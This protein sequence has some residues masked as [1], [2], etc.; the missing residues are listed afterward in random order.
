MEEILKEKYLRSKERK[1]KALIKTDERYKKA[2]FKMY[3]YYEID[4]KMNRSNVFT[5]LKKIYIDN[6]TKA[7]WYLAYICNISR[8]TLFGHRNEM[9]KCFEVCLKMVDDEKIKEIAITK[10]FD[11]K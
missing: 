10:D 4:D 2:F 7:S 5:V 8:T 6:V 3:S 9:L 1:L 11:D